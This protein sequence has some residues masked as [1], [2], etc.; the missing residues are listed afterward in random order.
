MTERPFETP[1]EVLHSSALSRH[2]KIELL[3]QWEYD[4]R[5]LAVATEEGMGDAEPEFLGRILRALDALQG[6]VD[7]EHRPSTEQG[8]SP[9][10]RE[11]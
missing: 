2:E 3:R 11:R 10:P 1:E 6:S 5:E 8:G 4:E 9:P 7:V